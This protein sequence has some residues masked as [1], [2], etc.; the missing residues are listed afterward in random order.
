[1]YQ[2]LPPVIEAC[3]RRYGIHMAWSRKRRANCFD[4][5]FSII[6]WKNTEC[7]WVFMEEKEFPFQKDS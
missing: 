3:I 2:P 5:G 6:F 1:M 7:D 4:F